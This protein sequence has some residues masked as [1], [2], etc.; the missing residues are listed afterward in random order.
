M[1]TET[2]K[3][4]NGDIESVRDIDIKGQRQRERQN[5]I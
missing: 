4:R 2:Y 3:E 5:W 1:E